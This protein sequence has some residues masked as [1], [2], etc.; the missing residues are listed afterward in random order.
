MLFWPLKVSEQSPG[1]ELETLAEFHHALCTATGMSVR[2]D[3]SNFVDEH[4]RTLH[5]RGINLG[6]NSKMPSK[7]CGYTWRRN[8]P[9]FFDHKRISFVNRPF[10]LSECDEH[11]GRLQK[12]GYTLL[13]FVI[14]WEAVEHEGPGLYDQEYLDYLYAMVQKA[15]DYGF[16]IWIDPHQVGLP[17]QPRRWNSCHPCPS[18]KSPHGESAPPQAPHPIPPPPILILIFFV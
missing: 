3:G 5:F 10:P 18:P 8:L 7:P 2:I 15:K 6:S 1:S 16:W 4:D 11:Y 13:R 9:N 17:M 14:T 12:W